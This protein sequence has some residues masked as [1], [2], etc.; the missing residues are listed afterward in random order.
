ML[1]PVN[2]RNILINIFILNFARIWTNRLTKHQQ[3]RNRKT[4]HSWESLQKSLISAY[5]NSIWVKRL[6]S[7]KSPLVHIIS[8]YSGALVNLQNWK[9][10]LQHSKKVFTKIVEIFINSNPAGITNT[11]GKKT[12]HLTL[13]NPLVWHRIE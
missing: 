5:M 1:R 8:S 7:A 10:Q 4:W 2:I 13:Y 3:L 6:Y 12:S 9:Q 11:T